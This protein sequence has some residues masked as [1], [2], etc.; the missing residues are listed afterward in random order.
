[1]E[2]TCLPIIGLNDCSDNNGLDYPNNTYG[3]GRVDALVAVQ[4]ALAVSTNDNIL[5]DM[6]VLSFPNPV[7]DQL[8]W[9]VTHYEGKITIKMFDTNG[10]MII[11]TQKMNQNGQLLSVSLKNQPNGI[12]FWQLEMDGMPTKSGKIMLGK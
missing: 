9:N 7:L 6:E 11:N 2:S 10:R 1:V 12:Y 3:Y 8:Y 4:K 5:T